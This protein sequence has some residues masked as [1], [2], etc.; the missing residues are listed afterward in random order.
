MTMPARVAPVQMITNALLDMLQAEGFRVGDHEPPKDRTFP[1]HILY[2]I[3]DAPAPEGPPLTG[4]EEDMAIGFQVTTVGSG[5]KQAQW[6]ADRVRAAITGRAA[7]GS[8]LVELP[9]V[10]GWSVSSR[11]GSTP[12]GVAPEGSAPNV[13]FNAPNRYTLHVTPA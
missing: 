11:L 3:E 12:S 7:D 4:P 1:Y 2:Q 5:R 8:F 6:G 13:L 9:V 10:A